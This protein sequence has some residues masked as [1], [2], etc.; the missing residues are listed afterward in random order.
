MIQAEF[1][2]ECS[3]VVQACRRIESP[4]MS[5][6]TAV[7]SPDVLKIDAAAVSASIESQ[8][9]EIVLQRL[10]RKG[11]VIAISGGI[12][13]SVVAALCFNALGVER[14]LGLMLPEADSSPDSL[15]F[16]NLLAQSLGL[17]THIEDIAAILTAAGCY[18]RRDEA[19]RKVIPQYAEGDKCKIVLPD[20]VNGSAYP[21]FSVVVESPLGERTKARL[22]LDSY[23]GVVAATNFKQRTRKMMEYYYADLFNYA[24][25][26][27]ANRLEY[28]QGFF[29]KNGDGAA[30]LKPIAHLYKTQV[31][32]LA[33]YLGIPE[34][35]QKRPPTTDTYPL[36]QS[37]EEFYFPLPYD[38]MDLCLYAK[39]HG[40]QP[41]EVAPVIEL[42]TEQV[43]RVYRVIDATR[44]ATRYLHR[45]PVL[46]EEVPEVPDVV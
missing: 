40:L 17:R 35:I 1:L 33:A 37:Q 39:N 42:T 31:Y 46:C 9:R 19:I 22:T 15:R 25:A 23:L 12:D 11:V 45:R 36:D 10:N 21:I 20:Q 18:Q 13:S 32:Q 8:I 4:A 41:E 14:V 16:A 6:A 3:S 5:I 43:S 28:D 29:V 34:E 7:F 2:L 38:R 30:D 27:T 44:N 26:G 24:V